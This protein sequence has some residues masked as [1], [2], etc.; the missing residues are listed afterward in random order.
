MV[1]LSDFSVG[2]P[3]KHVFLTFASLLACVPENTSNMINQL[4]VSFLLLPSWKHLE[5]DSLL[6]W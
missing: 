4:L 6:P 2:L 5:D 1:R 3:L